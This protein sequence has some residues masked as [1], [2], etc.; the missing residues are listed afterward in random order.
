MNKFCKAPTAQEDTLFKVNADFRATGN[1]R[2]A[3][4]SIRSG[5]NRNKSR[6][7]GKVTPAINSS[8]PIATTTSFCFY[9]SGGWDGTSRCFNMLYVNII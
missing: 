5:R 9:V 2:D 7:T 8:H 6:T 3:P 1:G 4:H